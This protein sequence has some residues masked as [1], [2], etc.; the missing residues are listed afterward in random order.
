MRRAARHSWVVWWRWLVT[1]TVFVTWVVAIAFQHARESNGSFGVQMSHVAAV[2]TAAWLPLCF[3][4]LAIR[5]LL[6]SL[7]DAADVAARPARRR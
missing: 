3:P 1:G 4:R 5:L 2:A 7:L 6:L